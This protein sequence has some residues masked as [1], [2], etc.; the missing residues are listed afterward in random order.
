MAVTFVVGCWCVCIPLSFLLLAYT[1]LGLLGLWT[2][3]LCG[4]SVATAIAVAAVWRSDWER[5]ADAA[6]ERLTADS[7]GGQDGTS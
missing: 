3:L 7:L 5:L 6:A 4:Y 2:A 1:G